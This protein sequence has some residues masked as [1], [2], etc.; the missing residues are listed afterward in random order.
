MSV[1]EFTSCASNLGTL[2]YITCPL[3]SCSA[4]IGPNQSPGTV[5]MIL[6]LAAFALPARTALSVVNASSGLSLSWILWNRRLLQKL[7]VIHGVGKVAARDQRTAM[8]MSDCWTLNWGLIKRMRAWMRFLC[9]W[10][11]RDN[12]SN[13]TITYRLQ[14]INGSAMYMRQCTLQIRFPHKNRVLIV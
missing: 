13:S 5:T 11:D 9:E 6:P 4:G 8:T 12:T 7:T 14:L 3:G 2:V 1:L 10:D